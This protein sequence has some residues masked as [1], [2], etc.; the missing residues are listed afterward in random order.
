MPNLDKWIFDNFEKIGFWK[1]VKNGTP[2]NVRN[3]K[4]WK[5]NKSGC[6]GDRGI[7]TL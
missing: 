7:T 4:I 5:C 6:C 1:C 2:G 3:L